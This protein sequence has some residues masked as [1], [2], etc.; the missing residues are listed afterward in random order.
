MTSKSGQLFFSGQ[1]LVIGYNSVW[2]GKQQGSDNYSTA[3]VP[4]L[5]FVNCLW[6]C[7]IFQCLPKTKCAM[8]DLCAYFI[9][10]CI[11]KYNWHGWWIQH[12]CIWEILFLV[13]FFGVAY[14]KCFYDVIIQYPVMVPEFY[15]K[16]YQQPETSMYNLR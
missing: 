12:V 5:W 10:R 14:M 8:T 9:L 7:K 1:K 4:K 2:S 16:C 13:A 15:L 11:Q 6:A 3:K